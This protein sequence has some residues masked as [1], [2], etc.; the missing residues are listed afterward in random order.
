MTQEVQ[1]LL[2]QYHE[3]LVAGDSASAW[4]LLSRRKQHQ[5]LVQDGYAKW[6]AAQESLAPYLDPSGIR[7]RILATDPATGVATVRVTGMTWSA[8][9]AK[10]KE[11]S[12][13]TWA[14][15]ESGTWKY[16]PGYSTTVA[17]KRQWKNRYNQLLGT[18]C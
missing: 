12:G 15:Y 17:R 3:D 1:A 18:Q 9:H 6:V 13:I 10:C 11:W 16:D 8:P 5:E 14:K 4:Q 2:L 7:V